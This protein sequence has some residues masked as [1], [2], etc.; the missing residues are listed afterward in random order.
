[1]LGLHECLDFSGVKK[2]IVFFLMLELSKLVA[3]ASS[4]FLAYST[5]KII[6]VYGLSRNLHIQELDYCYFRIGSK[7]ACHEGLVAL[8]CTAF[9]LYFTLTSIKE[10]VQNTHEPFISLLQPIGRCLQTFNPKQ[11]RSRFLGDPK[12][13][14]GSSPQAVHARSWLVSPSSP[15]LQMESFFNRIVKKGATQCRS[16]NNSNCQER[17]QSV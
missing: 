10:E 9:I 2:S 11:G 6:I 16:E 5:F 15:C 7:M 8:S 13:G 1:M 17:G 4:H 14:V 12:Q 3:S